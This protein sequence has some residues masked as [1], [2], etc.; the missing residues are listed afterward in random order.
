[1]TNTATPEPQTK[2]RPRREKVEKEKAEKEKPLEVSK[3][4]K[5]NIR[6]QG[7]GKVSSLS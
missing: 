4:W 5:G 6:M 3:T 2:T 7:W 1:M